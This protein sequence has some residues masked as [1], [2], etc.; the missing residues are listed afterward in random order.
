M[1]APA[2][3]Q[4]LPEGL[5]AR[6]WLGVTAVVDGD[7]VELEDGREVR[8]VG[9]QAPKLPLGRAGFSPWPLAGEA[10]TAVEALLLG[11]EVGL[12]YPP[13]G[14]AS[15]RYGRALAHLVTRDGLWIQGRLLELG[16]ARV[17][18]F[19]DNR[20]LV[21]EMLTLERRA[22][23]AGRGIWG[24]P[25]YRIRAAQAGRLW[26][27]L[28]SFQLVVG[29]VT[30]VFISSRNAYLN[31]GTDWRED[32]SLQIPGEASKL[33]AGEGIEL[34]SLQG[35]RVRVRGWITAYNGPLIRVTH[36]EQLEILE[37]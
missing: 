9:L 22:R 16:L 13:G 26:P 4:G 5:E 3:A 14:R 30:E 1:G 31:F 19:P 17:Y 2:K 18:S 24:H 35:R 12:V 23:L 20:A 11:R 37:P 10:K 8:F 21:A 32:F 6:E 25:C 28:D 15:D 7:T 27:L 36:P 33:F 29:E 34:E